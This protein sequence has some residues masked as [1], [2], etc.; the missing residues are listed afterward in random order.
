M[1]NIHVGCATSRNIYIY[2]CDITFRESHISSCDFLFFLLLLSCSLYP[3]GDPGTLRAKRYN[4]V[5]KQRSSRR[6]TACKLRSHGTKIT[7]I[8]FF[9]TTKNV[10]CTISRQHKFYDHS[11]AFFLF[12]LLRRVVTPLLITLYLSGK[13]IRRHTRFQRIHRIVRDQCLTALSSIEFGS[14]GVS[15]ADAAIRTS[16]ACALPFGPCQAPFVIHTSS[17]KHSGL[18]RANAPEA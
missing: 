10:L 6:G 16:R 14:H 12:L 9:A 17:F 4:F 15:S 1:Q 18:C 13:I 3:D 7:N 11:W 2:R 8:S 5:G